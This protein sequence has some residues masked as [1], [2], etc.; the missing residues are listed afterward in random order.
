[1]VTRLIMVLRAL[2]STCTRAISIVWAAARLDVAKVVAVELAAS[3]LGVGQLL[4]GRRLLLQLG[5]APGAGGYNSA[6]ARTV[7]ALAVVTGAAAVTSALRSFLQP[8]LGELTSR[9]T[10]ARMLER[11]G[12]RPLEDFDQPAFHNRLYR[13]AREGVGRPLELVW[14]LMDLATGLVGL[15]VLTGLLWS[16]L[17]EAV[18]LVLAAAVPL[19]LVGRLDAAAYHRFVERTAPLSRATNYL[20]DLLTSRRSAA[21]LRAYGLIPHLEDRH[22]HLQ[23]QRLAAL[24]QLFR[25]RALRSLATAAVTTIVTVAALGFIVRRAATGRLSVGDTVTIA[26]A[27]QQIAS[28][29][30]ALR[31]GLSTLH[32]NRLF[33]ADLTA[34]L[35]EHPPTTV[36]PAPLPA[37]PGSG[38]LELRNVTFTYP[39]RRRPAVDDVSLTIEPGQI[40]ALVGENGSGK[41][42]LAKLIGGLYQPH[43]GH[44]IAD[45]VDL[46]T[47]PAAQRTRHVVMV[48]QD[49]ARYALSAYDNVAFGDVDRQEDRFAVE[50]AVAL[51]GLDQI[52]AALS[53]GLETPLSSEYDGGTDLS[54]G[55]WQRVALARAF[56]RDAALLVLDEP[57]A[58]LDARAEHELFDRVR[59][60]A[61]GRS[62]LLISHRLAT[63]READLIVVMEAGRIAET[64]THQ[65]L[66]DANG[67]YWELNALQARTLVGR[68]PEVQTIGDK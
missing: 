44:V 4:L 1:M 11:V 62:V 19:A 66:M 68:G 34:F 15:V 25:A 56:F 52:V 24:R 2:W 20:Q 43:S 45:G 27:V 50:R 13:L 58:A 42:T 10:Y 54:S 3:A 38:H 31:G 67:L 60:L 5:A 59:R 22:S 8:L 57:A 39:G 29:L 16:L 9:Y 64:G 7:A 40:V 30:Q 46:G 28:R 33:L 49:F 61:T 35:D 18:P 36:A 63:V 21:E 53:N 41:T 51:G 55:Q 14:G 32:Q 65:R 12:A 17:P 23:Q 6:L 37:H 47:L 48:F 26:V